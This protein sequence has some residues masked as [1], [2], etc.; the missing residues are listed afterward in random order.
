MDALRTRLR[1]LLP[2]EQPGD[3]LLDEM[4]MHA[5]DT[6]RALTGR[7]DIPEGLQG[8]QLRLAV[9]C[10]NRLGTEGE[11]ARRE[12]SLTLTFDSLPQDV[13]QVLKAW[14]VAR[15]SS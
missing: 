8:V 11:H 1:A 14:R 6:V 10:Y 12:G 13:R 7:T 9:I 4:L 15:V 2:G 5:A 3:E